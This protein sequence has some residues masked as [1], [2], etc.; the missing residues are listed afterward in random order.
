MVRQAGFAIAL[1]FAAA[2]AGCAADEGRP[3]DDGGPLPAPLADAVPVQVGGAMAF[4]RSVV[5]PAVGLNQDLFEPTVDV[6]DRGTIYVS[7]H[8]IGAVTTGTPAYVSRD[9]GATWSPLP[10]AGDLATPPP[11]QGSAPPPGDEGYIVAGSDGRAWML[12]VTLATF[13]VTGWCGDGARQCSFNPDAYDRVASSTCAA[14]A[15]NDRPWGAF[16]NGTLLMVNNGNTGHV[17]VGVL[18]DDVVGSRWATCLA[19]GGLVTGVPALREDGVFAVPQR[20]ADGFFVVVGHVDDLENAVLRPAF[21]SNH[22]FAGGD[23]N[24]GRAA[25]DADGTL[26]VAGLNNVDGAGGVRVAASADDGLTFAARTFTVPTPV[27]WMHLDAVPGRSGAL[28]SWAQASAG[29]A[30]TWD[31]HAAHVRLGPGGPA[32]EDASAVATVQGVHGDVVG[33]AAGPDGRAYV[34]TYEGWGA[35]GYPLGNPV[36]VWVQDAGPTL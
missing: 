4:R 26:F 5:A 7:G 31:F 24:F 35:V 3:A 29:T 32:L 9:D 8:V 15:V 16:A 2:L 36:S 10:F 25:F 6:S 34:A 18:R 19:P 14:Q 28:L 27:G 13:P 30:D 21:R 1:A 17:E 11:G 23:G 12:D 33:C 22:T 20:R